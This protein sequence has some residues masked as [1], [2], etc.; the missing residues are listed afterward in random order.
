MKKSASNLCVIPLKKDK[1][2]KK[3]LAAHGRQGFHIVY[4]DWRTECFVLILA[5]GLGCKGLP[6]RTTA[7]HRRTTTTHG[8]TTTAWAMTRSMIIKVTVL[9]FLA[10]LEC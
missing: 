8:R 3:S 5:P 7:T 10:L 6:A 4:I 9:G 1:K 2:F